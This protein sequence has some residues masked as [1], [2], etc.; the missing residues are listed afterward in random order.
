M[1]TWVLMIIVFSSLILLLCLGVPIAFS[2][3][4]IS[5]I[6]II[7]TWGSKGLLLLFNS[8]YAESTSFLLLAIPLFVF[9]ANMLKFSGMGDDLY[10]MVYRWM[11]NIRGGLALGTVIIFHPCYLED[12][13]RIWPSAVLPQAALWG[14]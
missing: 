5:T 7:F 3:C 9:M 8:A 2:L 6:G 4:S 11:G 12:I 14:F 1:E 10:E 13:K